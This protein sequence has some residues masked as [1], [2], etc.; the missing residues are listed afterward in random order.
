MLDTIF[1]YVKPLSVPLN[2]DTYRKIVG[3]IF[4]EIDEQI[5]QDFVTSMESLKGTIALDSERFPDKTV[6]SLIKDNPISI[7]ELILHQRTLT[8]TSNYLDLTATDMKSVKDLILPF[9]T[10]T[11]GL[12]L[13]HV[14]GEKSRNVMAPFDDALWEKTEVEPDIP[15]FDAPLLKNLV[16]GK[17][18]SN[19]KSKVLLFVVGKALTADYLKKVPKVY[20]VH[21]ILLNYLVQVHIM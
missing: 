16:T 13:Q 6:G 9:W 4:G 14:K 17:Y 12:L 18:E 5:V 3:E 1:A 15:P 20:L 11:M 10:R 7:A 19:M 21:F 8:I 2:R